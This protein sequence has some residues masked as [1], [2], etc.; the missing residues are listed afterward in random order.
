MTKCHY[1]KCNAEATNTWKRQ[2]VCEDHFNCLQTR[3]SIE[4]AQYYAG[5]KEKKDEENAEDP[6][7]AKKAIKSIAEHAAEIDAIDADAKQQRKVAETQGVRGAFGQQLQQIEVV[8]EQMTKMQLEMNVNR[9]TQSSTSGHE[10]IERKFEQSPDGNIVATERV[11]KTNQETT[12]EQE[13]IQLKLLLEENRVDRIRI[14]EAAGLQFIDITTK[15]K[16]SDQLERAQQAMDP[17]YIRD[18]YRWIGYE[19]DKDVLNPSL[20]DFEVRKNR[21]LKSP[22]QLRGVDREYF[23]DGCWIYLRLYLNAVR[24][25]LD[26]KKLDI[27]QLWAVQEYH[28]GIRTRDDPE[29]MTY[30]ITE[31][32]L[33]YIKDERMRARMRQ[34][35]LMPK[36]VKQWW[37]WC[38]FIWDDEKFEWWIPELLLQS[39]EPFQDN[40]HQVFKVAALQE[41]EEELQKLAE[42][43]EH[44]LAPTLEQAAL[45]DANNMSDAQK[46]AAGLDPEKLKKDAVKALAEPFMGDLSSTTGGFYSRKTGENMAKAPAPKPAKKAYLSPEE[47]TQQ[48]ELKKETK[49][50]EAKQAT[51][52]QLLN[53]LINSEGIYVSDMKNHKFSKFQGQSFAEI[54]EM[55]QTHMRNMLSEGGAAGLDKMSLQEQ[56]ERVGT[57]LVIAR[58]Y[59]RALTD[60][61][62]KMPCILA[63]GNVKMFTTVPGTSDI[64]WG[65]QPKAW[66]RCV[67]SGMPNYPEGI[68]LPAVLLLYVQ[69]FCACMDTENNPFST[70]AECCCRWHLVHNGVEG[71]L[72]ARDNVA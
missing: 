17:K 30:C 52:M 62:A 3:K 5:K 46:R 4:N 7:K 37:V 27:P 23:E 12:A 63:G 9:A 10:L 53:D 42:W 51:H 21:L 41:K 64:I 68:F 2:D 67:F 38:Y 66:I 35:Y 43:K 47:K 44:S 54:E 58:Y 14:Q 1:K 19:L 29:D 69:N 22:K 72:R 45:K 31:H 59:I 15:E 8:Q 70:V 55:K 40:L 61:K 20:L 32:S 56:Y 6:V 34:D 50:K 39:H 36:A 13:Q 33:S 11:E 18:M 24:G 25:G 16:I 71:I 60:P 49:A 26:G 57:P 48:E 65:G 28:E